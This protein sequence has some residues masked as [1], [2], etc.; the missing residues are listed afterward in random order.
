VNGI[1]HTYTLDGTK[2]LRDAWGVNVIDPL[3][4][5][6]DSVYGL[7]FADLHSKG[8]RHSLFVKRLTQP[9]FSVSQSKTPAELI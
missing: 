3:Y 1:K 2:I 5:N 8:L 6:E 4:D 7:I 9:L